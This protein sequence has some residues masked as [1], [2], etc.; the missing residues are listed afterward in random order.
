MSCCSMWKLSWLQLWFFLSLVFS[1]F[2]LSLPQHSLCAFMCFCV[3]LAWHSLL[4]PERLGNHHTCCSSPHQVLHKSS[5]L[6]ATWHPIVAPTT[7]VTTPT[8]AVF[9][10][11]ILFGVDFALSFNNYRH[12][13]RNLP[14]PHHRP[15]WTTDQPAPA[16]STHGRTCLPSLCLHPL[17][18]TLLALKPR[19][20]APANHNRN[21]TRVGLLC[22]CGSVRPIRYLHVLLF[23]LLHVIYWLPLAI[24][25][26]LLSDRSRLKM[27]CKTG[28]KVLFSAQT[29]LHY[30]IVHIYISWINF[31]F[32]CQL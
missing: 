12:L 18:P 27:A 28:S 29:I 10:W 9:V 14:S 22:R 16:S 13:R 23:F 6:G 26:P 2:F 25:L 1:L 32:K 11:V 7:A 8:V 15:H 19:T 21:N 5:G 24:C 20:P 17:H 31:P 3:S 4:P 30:L